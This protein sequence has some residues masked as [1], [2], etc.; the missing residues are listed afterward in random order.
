MLLALWCGRG[1]G[2]H[3]SESGIRDLI[4][5]GVLVCAVAIC[6]WGACYS[7]CGSPHVGSLCAW[8]SGVCSSYLCVGGGT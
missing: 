3:V 7:D 6:V 8:S 5:S 1:V 4:V 2:F